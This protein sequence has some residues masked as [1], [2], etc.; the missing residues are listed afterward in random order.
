MG[1]FEHQVF[2]GSYREWLSIIFG[3]M[4]RSCKEIVLLHEMNGVSQ[5]FGLNCDLFLLREA[6]F[7]GIANYLHSCLY[8]AVLFRVESNCKRMHQSCLVTFLSI[9]LFLQCMTS[10]SEIDLIGSTKDICSY[11]SYKIGYIL[12]F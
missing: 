8:I 3:W 10:T 2:T 7:S 12:Y 11:G 1:G 4:R 5:L 6:P 9:L